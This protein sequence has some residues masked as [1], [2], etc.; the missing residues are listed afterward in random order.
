M[1]GNQLGTLGRAVRQHHGELIAAQA[2]H[3]T[4]VAH[5]LV[6]Q[7]GELAQHGIAGFV[8]QAVVH[9]SE[10]IQIDEQQG[11]ARFRGLCGL[12]CFHGLVGNVLRLRCIALQQRGGMFIKRDPI[13][14]IGQQIMRR[15]PHRFLA[16]VARRGHILEQPDRRHRRA[17]LLRHPSHHARPQQAAVLAAQR[18]LALV[19]T[20][21]RH[22]FPHLVGQLVILIV[23]G[24]QALHRLAFELPAR[25]AQH[26]TRL[27]TDQL[28]GVVARDDN[29]DGRLLQNALQMLARELRLMPVVQLLRVQQIQ[30]VG[31]Q[32]RFGQR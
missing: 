26:Q 12:R 17:P 27:L 4:H 20:A 23:V 10:V 14:Q 11:N 28:Q 5:Q 13:G 18:E 7:A 16:L 2:S 8:A 9:Q 25:I 6:E 30:R 15:G 21:L 29:A 32:F 31:Q 19:T 1:L 24:K 22:A 3:P